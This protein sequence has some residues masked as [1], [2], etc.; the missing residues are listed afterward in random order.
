MITTQM[1]HMPLT[2]EPMR[3]RV[4]VGHG[5]SGGSEIGDGRLSLNNKRG[6]ERNH[7]NFARDSLTL[8]TN[9]FRLARAFG[10][11]TE[12]GLWAKT[13]LQALEAQRWAG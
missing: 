12:V 7:Y 6:M 4:E 9:F 3:I 11:N 2:K 8:Q 5:N 13:V 1:H 10:A